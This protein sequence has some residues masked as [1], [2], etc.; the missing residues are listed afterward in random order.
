MKIDRFLKIPAVVA[1]VFGALT[2][3]SGGR[4]QPR[5]S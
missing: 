5:A 4:Q 1:I 3:F 2:V